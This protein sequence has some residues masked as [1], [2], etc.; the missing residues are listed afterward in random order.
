MFSIKKETVLKVIEEFPY[1]KEMFHMI[2]D[3][4]NLYS[5]YDKL[6]MKCFICKQDGHYAKYC[7][8]VHHVPDA[9]KILA[10]FFAHEGSFRKHHKRRSKKKKFHA[11]AG[12]KLLAMRVRDLIIDHPQEMK[13][14]IQ[15]DL[16]KSNSFMP[17]L[18]DA[19]HLQMPRVVG[20]RRRSRTLT[21]M[22]VLSPQHLMGMESV[23]KDEDSVERSDLVEKHKN[24]VI[25]KLITSSAP[26]SHVNIPVPND[27]EED[28]EDDGPKFEEEKF[29]KES[30]DEDDS[31]SGSSHDVNA[32]IYTIKTLGGAQTLGAQKKTLG[33]KNTLGNKMIGT[34]NTMGIGKKQTLVRKQTGA[35]PLG[36][37]NP[38]KLFIQAKTGAERQIYN[39]EIMEV[40]AED[41]TFT[42]DAPTKVLQRTSTMRKIIESEYEH[43]AI[44]MVMNYQVYFP[45]NNSKKIIDQIN[46]PY[47]YRKRDAKTPDSGRH[48][49]KEVLARSNTETLKKMKSSSASPNKRGKSVFV[50]TRYSIWQSAK[51][52]LNHLNLKRK[53]TGQVNVPSP[54][55]LMATKNKAIAG[56][57]P[58]AI[59]V[60][61]PKS[62]AE[63][64][65]TDSNYLRRMSK[66]LGNLDAKPPMIMVDPSPKFKAPK[67]L[68]QH[69]FEVEDSHDI[70]S[71]DLRFVKDSQDNVDR[72]LNNEFANSTFKRS[73]TLQKR[74][75]KRGI[76]LSPIMGHREREDSWR[77]HSPADSQHDKFFK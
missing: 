42:T 64:S 23:L 60:G 74:I 68:P 6:K 66:S 28:E 3:K 12:K 39:A 1:E 27:P 58:H 33:H 51:N 43:F 69:T 45:H 38:A 11:L 73:D 71:S 65:P 7:F 70:Q 62:A 5:D 15:S 52:T 67:F 29:S 40:T 50:K 30:S 24:K 36:N 14:Y 31:D 18:G 22:V 61:S 34:K 41:N 32:P 2:K 47:K 35:R 46:Q 37:P 48:K 56:L 25:M 4:I 44:D 17:H 54:L 57:I 75:V 16:F 55:G 49:I 19:N 72:S 9:A 77:Q 26:A 13:K 63:K 76:S 10:D 59:N 21:N 53:P 8:R 20:E